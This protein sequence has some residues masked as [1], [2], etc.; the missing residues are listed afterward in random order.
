MKR[1]GFHPDQIYFKLRNPMKVRYLNTKNLGD[2]EA[3][4]K[5]HEKNLHKLH[6]NYKQRLEFEKYLCPK[7]VKP[8]ITSR[9]KTPRPQQE[10]VSHEIVLARSP[11]TQATNEMRFRT[12][13]FLS[14]HEIQEY[15]GKLYRMP[16]KDQAM[17]NTINHM[18]RVMTDRSTRKQ[19]RKADYKTVSVKLDYEV[20]PEF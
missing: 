4:A 11:K 18:G 13:Q 6:E 20:D 15:L 16:F 12:S 7:G 17:P 2:F 3:P 5:T 8:T 1:F 9:F 19:W 14:K 10:F